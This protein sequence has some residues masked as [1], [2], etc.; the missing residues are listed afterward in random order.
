MKYSI[1]YNPWKAFHKNAS[2][3]QLIGTNTIGNNS[4]FFKQPPLVNVPN[5]TPIDHLAAN[6][7]SKQQ[8]LQAL[9]A[10]RPL[11]FFTKSLA[12]VT[13]WSTY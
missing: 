1:V 10:E 13:M 5:A 7:F 3:K 12:I 2:L 9:K 11:Q 8:H 6:K 4:K